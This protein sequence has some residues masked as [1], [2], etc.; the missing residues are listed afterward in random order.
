MFPACDFH[1][2]T[3]KAIIFSII[4]TM[5]WQWEYVSQA[6]YI[7]WSNYASV[8]C[9][10]SQSPLAAFGSVPPGI[11]HWL[12]PETQ[13]SHHLGWCVV[14]PIHR[15]RS[16]LHVCRRE[17]IQLPRIQISQLPRSAHMLRWG[18]N[19]G[20]A[21]LP[22]RF[23][24]LRLA[25]LGFFIPATVS[26]NHTAFKDEISEISKMQRKGPAFPP[27]QTPDKGQKC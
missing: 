21:N 20:I 17:H 19:I 1:W 12:L 11:F 5:M 6:S 15:L 10:A 8:Q 14:R 23:S 2:L 16:W 13:T 7:H 25:D 18:P 4:V 22:E 9:P 26:C 3:G 24:P 27:L